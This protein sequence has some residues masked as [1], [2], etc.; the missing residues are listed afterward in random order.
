MDSEIGDI[1]FIVPTDNA[2]LPGFE[3]EHRDRK[4]TGKLVELI[5]GGAMVPTPKF[6]V[7]GEV[8]IYSPNRYTF[9]HALWPIGARGGKRTRR[10]RVRRSRKNRSS[11]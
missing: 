1:F 11:K 8:K 5:K 6:D 3:R 10:R 7:G 4:F 2:G 9:Y